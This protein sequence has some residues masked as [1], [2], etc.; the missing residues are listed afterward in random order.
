MGHSYR[1]GKNSGPSGKQHT[2]VCH[3]SVSCFE[4]IVFSSGKCIFCY[5]LN[6]V[7][8]S[9][10]SLLHHLELLLDRLWLT[11]ISSYLTT[12]LSYLSSLSLYSSP[13]VLKEFFNGSIM[14]IN[15]LL[16]NYTFLT[17]LWVK[18]LLKYL[19]GFFSKV[20]FCFLH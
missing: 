18:N 14:F 4:T 19:W 7:F 10:L 1:E 13:N 12:F 16:Y 5:I 17:L 11:C 6:Y 15:C 2:T 9:L 3:F 20:F 8:P